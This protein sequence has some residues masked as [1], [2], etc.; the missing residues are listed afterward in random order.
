MQITDIMY[1]IAAVPIDEWEQ[2]KWIGLSFYRQERPQDERSD[3]KLLPL[4]FPSYA[5]PTG[6]NPVTHRLCYAQSGPD[7]YVKMY[8]HH[9]KAKDDPLLEDAANS[10]IVEYSPLADFLEKHGLQEVM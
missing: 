6:E 2:C 5:S 9:Q 8:R 1:T 4:M 7:Y 10:I 3:E